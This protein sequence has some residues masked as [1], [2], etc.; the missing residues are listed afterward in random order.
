MLARL[1]FVASAR[2]GCQ[3]SPIE[4]GRCAIEDR[5]GAVTEPQRLRNAVPAHMSRAVWQQVNAGRRR[6]PWISGPRSSTHGNY[7]REVRSSTSRGR[8]FDFE[9]SCKD[10]GGTLAAASMVGEVVSRH[11]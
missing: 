3:R 7:L 11:W 9:F 6:A 8:S 2:R 10:F 4:D 5:E 1:R